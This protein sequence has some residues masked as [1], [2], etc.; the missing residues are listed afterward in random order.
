MGKLIIPGGSGA[1]SGSDECSATR[2][3]VLKGYSAITTDSNDESLEGTLELSGDAS[4]SQVLAGRTYYNTNPKS[5]RTGN[6]IN[7]GAVSKVLNAGESFIIPSGYHNGTGKVDTTSLGSQTVGSATAS[8][9]INGQIAW[10]NGNKV[11]GNLTISSVVNFNVAQYAHLTLLASWALPNHGPWSGIRILCK[12][13]G[14]PNDIYDGNLFYEGSGTYIT[15]QQAKGLWYFRAWNY[16][17][18]NNGR[19]Y[20][21]YSQALISNNEI[22]GQQIFNTSDVLTVPTNVRQVKVFLVGGGGGGGGGGS[23]PYPAGGGGGAGGNTNTRLVSVSPGQKIVVT[24]GAGGARGMANSS[25][26]GSV[27]GAGGQTSFGSISAAGGKG[28][29]AGGEHSYTGGS[30][31]SGGGGGGDHVMSSSSNDA[32][33]SGGSNGS[34]GYGSNANNTTGG[35]GQQTTTRAYQSPSGSLYA[36]GGGGGGSTTGYKTAYGGNGGAG[37]GGNGGNSYGR[38]GI[39]DGTSGSANTGGG[40]G[41]GGGSSYSSDRGGY[42]GA[43]G[44]GICLV[45]WGSYI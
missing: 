42:G 6:M 15:K 4:D 14:Y 45:C 12:Q 10:V 18:T 31:G 2:A 19:V 13:G 8:Q 36:G 32:G 28:G 29:N 25:A 9:I 27:G 1:G 35:Y 38:N 5:K 20:G 44:S 21:N 3:E 7:Q 23:S 26:S 24:I 39:T 37:G 40:G 17:T 33:G 11:I 16:M 34:N 22:N 30:G 41:G 43:G